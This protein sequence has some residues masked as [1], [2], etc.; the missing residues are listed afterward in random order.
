MTDPG[1]VERYRLPEQENERIFRV[2]IV[3]DLLEGRAS[4]ET[5]TVVFLV[6]QPGA[7]KSRVTEMVASVLN[8]HGG[9]A[10]VDSDLYKPYHPT[11][12]TRR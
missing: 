5:P 8:R 11:P 12:P 3:P 2:R 9:F 6:G 1:E 7:G 10:D 4:Q